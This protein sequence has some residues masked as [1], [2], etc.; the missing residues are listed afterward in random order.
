MGRMPSTSPVPPLTKD[1][2][3]LAALFTT[4]GAIHFVRPE[5]YESIVPKP[6]HDRKR[7]LVY[8][9]GAVELLC[10]LGLLSPRT[11]KVAGLA[12]AALLVAVFPANVQMAIDHGRRAQRKG[13]PQSAAFFAGTLARLPLQWPM[14]RTALKAAGRR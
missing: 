6:L 10:A 12:S 8:V 1:I 11:R 2:A 7:E 4:S 13:T 5:V 9:S 14:V 3:G